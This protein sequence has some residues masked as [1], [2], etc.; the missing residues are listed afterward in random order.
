L[1]HHRAS[2]GY[3]SPAIYDYAQ[4]GIFDRLISATPGAPLA[5]EAQALLEQVDPYQYSLRQ[6]YPMPKF[7][8]NATGDE[9]FVPDTTQFYFDELQ[10]TKHLC[11]IPNVGHGM[12]GLDEEDITNP[13]S[14]A[15][16]LLAWYMTV[17][18][19]RPL[20]S[21]TQT[22]EEDGA[23]RVEID[24]SNPPVKVRL[25]QAT[26]E[27]LRDFRDPILGQKWTSSD[28]APL[29]AGVYRARPIEPLQGNYTGFF[30]QLEYTN[31]AQ[32]PAPAQLA[33]YERPNLVFSTGVRVLPVQVG[34]A[35]VY[36]EFNGYIANES[37]AV[38]FTQDQLPVAVVYGTPFA[39]G[40]RYGELLA[41][42]INAFVP[43][44]LEDFTAITSQ[45]E[46]YLTSTWDALSPSLDSRILDEIAG[47][48]SAPGVSISLT[49]LQMAHAAMIY[50]GG[51][52]DSTAT[53]AYGN[54]LAPFEGIKPTGHGIT[55]NTNLGL[56]LTDHLCTVVYIPNQ[57]LPHTVFTFAGLAF[58]LTGIN[59]GGISTSEIPNPDSLLNNAN[60]LPLLRSV[61]Y[62]A[63]SLR[64]AI[65]LVTENLPL[66][67]TL[68]IGDSRNENRAVR[69][70]AGAS[71]VEPI[72]R[73][74]LAWSEFALKR[75]GIVYD[76]RPDL[77][78]ALKLGLN[79]VINNLDLEKLYGLVNTNPFA[80]P[81]QNI[82]NVLYEGITLSITANPANKPLSAYQNQPGITFYMQELLP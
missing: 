38:P 75:P 55:I 30:I 32:L 73:Y 61:L 81:G 49:S 16:M 43:E 35:P 6:R 11:Y 23:I 54:M 76:T 70:R 44:F 47:I 78:T 21:F 40:Q 5:E 41:E 71:G 59:L 51:L 67:T 20:P 66:N 33:G 24:K 31:P 57:G 58:G 25:W 18:Q 14:P 15:G 10:G 62:D 1:E 79:T 28:L 46:E 13:A 72:L 7:M 63:L 19:K 4:K 26:S 80:T 29:S 65:A 3:W 34:G 36:P 37:D 60:A 45:S 82:L 56:D 39:M 42:D 77:Q 53:M 2:Y 27:G 74:D 12:G 52:W 17:T 8:L 48:A 50:M 68:V 64:D 69:I 22:F 9:F